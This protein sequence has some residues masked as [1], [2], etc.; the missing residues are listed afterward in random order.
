MA[1]GHRLLAARRRARRRVQAAA[2]RR[3]RARWTTTS[4]TTSPAGATSNWPGPAQDPI[5]YSQ[6]RSLTFYYNGLPGR[7][8]V[9]CGIDDVKALR[10]LDERQVVDPVVE[11]GDQRFTWYGTLREGQY[12]ILWPGE[13]IR[14]YGPPLTE[15]E[16]SATPA[17]TFTL[18]TGE[19]TVRFSAGAPWTMPV[20]VRVTLQPPERYAVP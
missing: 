6:V 11:V 16:S 2:A 3:P 19:H 9:A 18:P 1:Q 8:T 17:E 15:P 14:R 12:L 10:S 5:D 7:K 20:R 13:P 4:P